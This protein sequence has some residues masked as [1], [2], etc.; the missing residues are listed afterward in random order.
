MSCSSLFLLF[1]FTL[2]IHFLVPT[3]GK[4]LPFQRCAPFVCGDQ[5]ISYPFKHNE[6]PS[7]CGYPGYKLDCDGGNLT[8]LSMES[9]KYQVIHM[10]SSEQILKVSRMDLLKDICHGTPVNTT[11]NSSLF[12]YASHYL[13]STLFYNCNSPSTP[14][15]DRFSCPASGDG[16]FAFKVD[17]PSKLHKLCNFSVFVPFIPILEGSKSANISRDTVRDILKNGFEITWIANT[18]LC[19]NCT[20]SGG[21]CGYNWTRQE[22]SCFCRDKAY[23]TTCPA[24][25]GMYARVTVAN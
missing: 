19:E 7:Y 18:S 3:S 4:F 20:K 22:F 17:P 6:R 13:N 8:L 25:S 16:Y 10:D 23:P 12:N 2:H 11:L 24:P 15:P 1:I 14:Q 5:K 9:L 21:R